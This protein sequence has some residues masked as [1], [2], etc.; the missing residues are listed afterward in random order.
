MGT[1]FQFSLG[2][3]SLNASLLGCFISLLTIVGNQ[4]VMIW[5]LSTKKATMPRST[6][7]IRVVGLRRFLRYYA[8]AGILLRN[9][10][11]SH[12]VISCSRTNDRTS[13]EAIALH[14]HGGGHSNTF[15]RWA[16]GEQAAG[17]S[18]LRRCQLTC[19]LNFLSHGKPRITSSLSFKSNTM[20]SW[21]YWTSFS[22]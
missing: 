14:P 19:G 13:R 7:P 20:N 15:V 18:T 21:S 4:L 9:M 8:V 2:T 3:Y 1:Y 5:V 17:I 11:V 12:I 10:M 16:S 6:R 22:V